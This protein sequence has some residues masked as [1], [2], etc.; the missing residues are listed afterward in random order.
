MEQPLVIIQCPVY[1]FEDVLRDCLEGIVMQ[2]T[3]FPFYAV[4]YDDAS[5]DNSVDIIRGYAEKYPDIIRPIYGTEN[6]YSKGG[7]DR[8]MRIIRKAS[9]EATYIA[10]CDTDDY[11]TDPLKLQKQVDYLETHPDCGVV[12]TLINL[13]IDGKVVADPIVKEQTGNSPLELL[14]NNQITAM[15][16]V[17][18]KD[19]LD[20]AVEINEDKRWLTP[21]YPLWLASVMF[22]KIHLIN[23]ITGVYRILTTSISHTHHDR[24]RYEYWKNILDI[25]LFF[26]SK[27]LEQ[28]IIPNKDYELRFAE[29]VFHT[30]K[31]MLLDYRWIAREQFC[32]LLCTPLKVW[33][34][35]IKSKIT[36]VHK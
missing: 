7:I 16:A 28:G 1:N 13:N 18:R 9:A 35:V 4:V 36:R 21:D 11:W 27:Y 5:T 6:Q 30:R 14:I 8:V 17:I 12:H 2:Q 22:S 33:M 25:Q 20:R 24:N 23:E 34:Y 31:R 3:T 26:Y 29:M 10:Y 15:T 19:V 32:S